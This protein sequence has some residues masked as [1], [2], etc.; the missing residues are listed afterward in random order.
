MKKG[1][2][3]EKHITLF[4]IKSPTYQTVW[5]ENAS[6]FRSAAI[7]VLHDTKNAQWPRCS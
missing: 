4:E 6:E 7:A 1:E 5:Y 3:P 2:N